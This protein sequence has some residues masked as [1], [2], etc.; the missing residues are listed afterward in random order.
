MTPSGTRERI[1]GATLACVERWGL[2]KTSIEDV[3]REA[4][5][6]RATVYRHFP[7]GREELVRATV[8]WEVDRFFR[9]LEAR[10]AEQPDLASK[11]RVGLVFGRRA[12]GEH[13][14]LQR[15]LRTEPEALLEE[16][17][18]VVPTIEQLIRAYLLALLRTERLQLGV[19]VGAAADYL[20]RMFLSYLGSPGQWDLSDDGEVDR[21][22][23]TQFLAGILSG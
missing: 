2:V 19:D 4:G 6:S 16:L 14:L 18:Q 23:R 13:R 21:L 9:R 3:A 22:V 7:G 10:I 20:A 8:E 15:V 12:I 11:L 17:S 5:L 1:L